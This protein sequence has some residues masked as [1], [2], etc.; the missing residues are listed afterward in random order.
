MQAMS[1]MAQKT[2]DLDTK[3]LAS[4]SSVEQINEILIHL[5]EAHAEEQQ[6][7]EEAMV[8]LSE[9]VAATQGKMNDE[10]RKGLAVLA[11]HH[12]VCIALVNSMIQ[13]D[14]TTDVGWRVRKRHAT[15]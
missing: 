12:A 11:E 4:I 13:T 10:A 1:T 5:Y 6:K 2:E 15:D 3:L 14:N 8:E 7:W 9:S